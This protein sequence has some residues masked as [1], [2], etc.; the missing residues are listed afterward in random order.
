MKLNKNVKK[1]IVLSIAV[2]IILFLWYAS[3]K[4]EGILKANTVVIDGIPYLQFTVVA[5]STADIVTILDITNASGYSFFID[6]FSNVASK[7][8]NPDETVELKSAMI[9]INDL[10]IGEHYIEV[11]VRQESISGVYFEE[12]ELNK[13]L[14]VYTCDSGK[15]ISEEKP[16]FCECS[17]CSTCSDKLQDPACS[18]VV[19][20]ADIIDNAKGV[21]RTDAPGG[22]TC[23]QADGDLS[24]SRGGWWQNWIGSGFW[25]VTDPQTFDCQNHIIDG[26]SYPN[27]YYPHQSTVSTMYTS[28]G[29]DLGYGV[30]TRKAGINYI[31]K[32]CVITEHDYGIRSGNQQSNTFINNKITSNDLGIMIGGPYY[33]PLSQKTLLNNEICDNSQ[34]FRFEV[35]PPIEAINNTCDASFCTYGC[36]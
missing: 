11:T 33:L 28:N 2:L 7:S 31:I 19:L 14:W 13:T 3:T 35:T 34:D 32:N 23:I 21:L 29:I 4:D 24:Q 26:W 5:K 8:V 30:G 18:V 1:T 27:P 10:E 17:D 15:C 16:Q 20:T 22:V 25:G 12:Y 6:S 36:T 9:P